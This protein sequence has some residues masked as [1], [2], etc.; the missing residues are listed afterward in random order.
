MTH[1][2]DDNFTQLKKL[3]DQYLQPIGVSSDVILELFNE[4]SDWAFIVQLDALLDTVARQTLR[5]ALFFQKCDKSFS[6]K[7]AL[8]DF[9]DKLP[10]T[11]GASVLKLLE[12]MGSPKEEYK[13]VKYVRVIRNKYAHDIRRRDCSILEL[14]HEANETRQLFYSFALADPEFD[15]E[16]LRGMV[17]GNPNILRMTMLQAAMVFLYL[18]HN[19]LTVSKPNNES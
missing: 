2:A 9:V 1:N 6:E 5:Q 14:I 17:E 8:G 19:A 3:S 11:G 15:Y 10:Y 7:G 4:Q 16:E 13:F 12:L 18:M